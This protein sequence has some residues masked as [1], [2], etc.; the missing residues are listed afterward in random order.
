[1]SA[2][3]ITTKARAAAAAAA[4][5]ASDHPADQQLRQSNA[6][7]MM[8]AWTQGHLPRP[9]VAPATAM[10]AAAAATTPRLAAPVGQGRGQE[11]PQHR[12]GQVEGGLQEL[13]S[14]AAATAS[15][16]TT[17]KVTTTTDRVTTVRNSG[18]PEVGPEET[19]EEGADRAQ[20][21]DSLKEAANKAS[22]SGEEPES[23][24]RLQAVPSPPSFSW[25]QTSG[26]GLSGPLLVAALAAAALML[27]LAFNL[28]G[29][30]I[31]LQDRAKDCG[32]PKGHQGHN[33]LG[34]PPRTLND[35]DSTP[36]ELVFGCSQA[37]F[38]QPD[39]TSGKTGT[40]PVSTGMTC[41]FI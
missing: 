3:L 13:W 20:R 25:D 34:K 19:A 15:T 12:G 29:W 35:D 14:K 30:K 36:P 37:S 22:G 17:S 31:L 9:D 40:S 16:A 24:L 8:V 10:D 23:P 18:Q 27:A 39:P 21:E 11:A 33:N 5:V 32:R 6:I 2:K 4:T 28:V 26:G 7:P 38:V 41:R 1:M